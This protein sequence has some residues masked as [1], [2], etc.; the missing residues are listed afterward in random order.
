MLFLCKR[1]SPNMWSEGNSWY[2]IALQAVRVNNK[3]H[4]Q[5]YFHSKL[6]NYGYECGKW[7]HTLLFVLR[8]LFAFFLWKFRRLNST[9][10]SYV[11]IHIA[12][13]SQ[14]SCILKIIL[15]QTLKNC[16]ENL[17]IHIP[18]NRKMHSISATKLEFYDIKIILERV[19]N[20]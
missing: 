1:F 12:T 5:W 18:G 13:Q 3:N 15:I 6:F 4:K 17:M 9:L 14:H 20:C 8:V 19:R 10:W 7:P 16:H 2:C 11:R